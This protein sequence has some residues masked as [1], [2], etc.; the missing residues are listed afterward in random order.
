MEIDIIQ[1]EVEVDIKKIESE[2]DTHNQGIKTGA[3]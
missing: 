3:L 2:Q 1:K